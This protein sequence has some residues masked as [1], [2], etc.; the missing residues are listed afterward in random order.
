MN[1]G[2]L[3]TNKLDTISVEFF[4]GYNDSLQCMCLESKKDST[5]SMNSLY[6]AY[7]YEVES[8]KMIIIIYIYFFF[9]NYMIEM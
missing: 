7:S 5:S 9:L 6:Y 1:S 4:H 2:D 3:K 8:A